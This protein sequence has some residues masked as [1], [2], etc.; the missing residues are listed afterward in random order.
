LLRV[1]P[2]TRLLTALPPIVCITARAW[3]QQRTRRRHQHQQPQDL[4]PTAMTRGQKGKSVPLASSKEAQVAASSQ[5]LRDTT[6]P[7]C[8]RVSACTSALHALH[9]SVP[10]PVSAAA[11]D[12]Q[13]AAGLVM[14]MCVQQFESVFIADSAQRAHLHMKSQTCTTC[15]FGAHPRRL[16]NAWV[17]LSASPG[18]SFR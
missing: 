1:S 3:L 14:A 2:N 5:S 9:S 16:D 12:S 7:V 10:R 11:D 6:V 4:S 17:A 8:H 15:R 13:R 18:S